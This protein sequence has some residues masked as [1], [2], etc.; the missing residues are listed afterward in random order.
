M[1]PLKTLALAVRF[2]FT[3]VEKD[4]L[5]TQLESNTKIDNKTQHNFYKFGHMLF[6]T[7]WPE[8]YEEFWTSKE[9][10][11][12]NHPFFKFKS[13]QFFSALLQYSEHKDIIN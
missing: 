13:N 9:P 11:V 8:L 1:R 12:L 3:L 7:A 4:L 6:F 10:K 2:P 5:A